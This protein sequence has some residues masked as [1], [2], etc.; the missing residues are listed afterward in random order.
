MLRQRYV[1]HFLWLLDWYD[2]SGSGTAVSA[3]S[4]YLSLAPLLRS[5]FGDGSSSI[6]SLGSGGT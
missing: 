1:P 3:F 2:I 4:A 6:S 5:W